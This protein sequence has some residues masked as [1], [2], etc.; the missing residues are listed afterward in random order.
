KSFAVT[1]GFNKLSGVWCTSGQI[2]ESAIESI[3]GLP[4]L[5][6]I[7]VHDKA[8]DAVIE[9]LIALRGQLKTL[10]LI[11]QVRNEAPVTKRGYALLPRLVNVE[12]LNFRR[13]Q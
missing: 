9:R 3:R 12:D 5:Q 7:D 10:S 11:Q 4:A 6:I 2:T 8:S 1:K 13:N